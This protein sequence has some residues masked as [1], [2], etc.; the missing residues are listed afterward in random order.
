MS[1]VLHFLNSYTPA[2]F[3]QAVKGLAKPA[4]RRETATSYISSRATT[5]WQRRTTHGQPRRWIVEA[6]LYALIEGAG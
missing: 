3:E 5:G 2:G 1:E 4:E 6:T